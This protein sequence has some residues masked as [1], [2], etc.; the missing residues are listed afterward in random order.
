MDGINGV[1][2]LTE[3]QLARFEAKIDKGDG[4]GCWEWTGAKTTAGYGLFQAGL[5][6]AAGNHVPEYAH[7]IS[8]EQYVRPLVD[9]ETIDHLCRNPSCVRPDHLEPVPIRVNILRGNS[10]SARHA[11]AVVCQ[12]GHPKTPENTYVYPD[13]VHECRLC[14]Q[15][16]WAEWSR[17]RGETK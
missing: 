4:T 10:A 15:L 12:R 3:K 2:R 8:Y 7:R 11:R 13:G 16:R 5:R 14:R 6:S 1:H 9:G 17:K